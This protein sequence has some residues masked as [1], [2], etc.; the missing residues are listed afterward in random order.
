MNRTVRGGSGLVVR[1]KHKIRTV[2][3][4]QLQDIDDRP[5]DPLDHGHDDGVSKL[6][7]GLGVR[8]WNPIVCG[9]PHQLGT[10]AGRQSARVFCG[11]L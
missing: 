8:H 2:A 4:W 10:F 3:K 9:V 1:Q 7:I 6:T 5:C 11:T